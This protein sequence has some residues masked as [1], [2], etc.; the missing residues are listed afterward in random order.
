MSRPIGAWLLLAVA[1]FTWFALRVVPVAFPRRWRSRTNESP[2]ALVAFLST[3]SIVGLHLV[4]LRVG[5][6][7]SATLPAGIGA[8]FGLFWLA[9][10]LV[11]PRIRRNPSSAS[12]R[13]G[14]SRPTR[15]GRARTIS[16]ATCSVRAAS[17]QSRRPS[18]ARWQRPYWPSSSPHSC[19]QCT[20][21]S[22]SVERVTRTRH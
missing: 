7:R 14:P 3:V 20:R 10:S 15:T 17:L 16:P 18:E 19:Q 21:S 2:L 5:I 13:H 9:L 1:L 22:C 6:L 12:A 4:S 11:L 8:L